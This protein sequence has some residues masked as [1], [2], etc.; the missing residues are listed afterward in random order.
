MFGLNGY[1]LKLQIVEQ[2]MVMK[3]EREKY[4]RRQNRFLGWMFFG[5]T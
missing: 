4:P 3:I 1:K 5:K 2:G